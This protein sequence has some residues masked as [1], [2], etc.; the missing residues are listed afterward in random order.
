MGVCSFD[1][2]AGTKRL[3]TRYMLNTE[4][5]VESLLKDVNK[6]RETAYTRGDMASIDLLVDLR[7]A[8]DKSG[9]TQ[10]QRLAIELLYYK[11]L[12]V[13]NVASIMNC[14]ISTVSRHRKAG[15]KH[16]TKIFTKWE[17]V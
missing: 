3:E 2:E 7:H 10:K 16:I 9:M 6:I 1:K 12:S 17:Y 4:E 8:I 5:G 11:D 15:L 13:I 14:D